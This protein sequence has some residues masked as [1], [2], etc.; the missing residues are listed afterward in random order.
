[1]KQHE[2]KNEK[3]E[4][5]HLSVFKQFETREKYLNNKL[6][7]FIYSISCKHLFISVI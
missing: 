6:E 2:I 4:K 5:I 1:M 7:N 3:V